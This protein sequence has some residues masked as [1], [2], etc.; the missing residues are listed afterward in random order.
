VVVRKPSKPPLPEFLGQDALYAKRLVEA[1][2][3][4][5]GEH[6]AEHHLT[7]AAVLGSLSWVLGCM[8]GALARDGQGDLESLGEFIVQQLRRAA[9]GEFARRSYT[10]H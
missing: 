8:I 3:L 4:L 10:I 6:A 2:T 1:V 5:V 7:E 9:V